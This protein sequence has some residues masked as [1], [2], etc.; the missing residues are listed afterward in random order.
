VG[1]GAAAHGILSQTTCFCFTIDTNVSCGGPCFHD[2]ERYRFAMDAVSLQHASTPLSKW[3]PTAVI[4]DPV[5]AQGLVAAV[6]AT[7][8]NTDGTAA[9][10]AKVLAHN[11]R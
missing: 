3:T 9:A 6:V 1:V 10:L 11:M 4:A 5:L 7:R 8:A 2:C